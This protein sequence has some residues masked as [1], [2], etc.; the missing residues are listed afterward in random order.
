MG[1]GNRATAS[2]LGQAMIVVP[3]QSV[4]PDKKVVYL[5]VRLEDALY[6]LT[7]L[8]LFLRLWNTP[9]PNHTDKK[10]LETVLSNS[11]SVR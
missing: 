5:H 4:I 8:K 2:P 11:K 3:E 10:L 1:K 6:E 7:A 9:D